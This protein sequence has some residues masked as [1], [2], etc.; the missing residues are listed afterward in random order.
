[1]KKF[2]EQREKK[3]SLLSIG[4]FGSYRNTKTDQTKAV[5]NSFE[6]LKLNFEVFVRLSNSSLKN[7]HNL[8]PFNKFFLY[9][10]YILEKLKLVK[11]RSFYINYMEKSFLRF[12][13]DFDYFFLISN[14]PKVIK[15]I[16]KD[17]KV[18]IIQSTTAHECYNF[19]ISKKYKIPRNFSDEERLFQD[20]ADY[21]IATSKF[22]KETF[23]K[24]GFNKENIYL[25]NYG[26]NVNKFKP[27][28]SKK[29]EEFVVLAVANYGLLKGFQ[30]LLKA[31]VNLNLKNA[32]LIILGNPDKVMRKVIKD[33]KR[34]LTIEFV[35]FRSPVSYLQKASIFVHPSLTEGACRSI[36]E[37]LSSGLPVICTKESGSIVEDGK[38]GF[39]IEKEN[40][41]Q[42]EEKIL[43]LYN[44]RNILD[45]MSEQARKTIVENY[46]WEHYSQRVSFAIEDIIKREEK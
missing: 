5:V 3:F 44:N 9:F 23:I 20:S 13:K 45:K 6:N 16:K 4:D 15:K 38:E 33:Y 27:L 25:T 42:I 37:A 17:N 40:V 43:Y 18:S 36:Y 28:K 30:F 34:N 2:K 11:A 22:A 35:S 41:K 32:K 29:L 39:I 31:W 19:Q 10:I 7:I 14:F 26:V 1:M 24:G 12:V 8:L 21:V 46:S